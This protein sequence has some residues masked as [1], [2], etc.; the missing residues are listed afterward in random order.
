MAIVA[1]IPARFGSTRLP[2]KPLS[3]INGKPMVQ[4]VWER[5]RASPAVDRVLIATDDERIAEVVRAFGGEVAMTS[6]AHATGTDRLAEA[7]AA[8]DADIVVNVQGDEPMLD[9]A[10]IDG[11]VAP[12][13][14]EPGLAMSTISL[15][16][17]DV[18]EM[19][20]SAV[21][22]V[23]TD[24]RGDALYFSRSPIPFVRDSVDLRAAAA[25]AI[26]RGLARKHVGLYAYRREALLRF[27]AL[28]PSPLELVE[29][30]EQ[31]RALH[32]GLR[33]RVV[34]MEGRSGVA[35]DTPQDL[36]RVRAM[37][38]GGGPSLPYTRKTWLP[39]TSS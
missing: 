37:M 39:N 6:R 30:L 10:F 1:I 27:A 17:T 24:A 28:P 15:P 13:L 11:A 8:T 26:G 21:V 25:Q 7:A 23:V 31:L 9:P 4:H 12:L 3:Q 38:A 2:G 35:V 19:L 18:E 33:I 14:A 16:V 5:A 22:K 29:S 36:E 34:A 20:S 32:D